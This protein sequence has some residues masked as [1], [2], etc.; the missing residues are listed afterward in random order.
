MQVNYDFKSVVGATEISVADWGF[1]KGHY[2]I[3]DSPKIFCSVFNTFKDAIENC[4]FKDDMPQDTV[5]PNPSW[6]SDKGKYIMHVEETCIGERF[7]IT[8]N[9]EIVKDKDGKFIFEGWEMAHDAVMYDYEN[10]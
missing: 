3:V 10:S 7:V 8:K 6:E 5:F 1:V 4:I 9:G 2:Y